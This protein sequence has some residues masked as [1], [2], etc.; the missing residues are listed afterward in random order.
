MTPTQ[1]W[2]RPNGLLFKANDELDQADIFAA[3]I[4]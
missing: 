2:E 1:W 4:L 3:A